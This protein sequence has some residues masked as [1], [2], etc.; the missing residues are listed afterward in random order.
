ML[1]KTI[2]I[3]RIPAR[4][5]PLGRLYPVFEGVYLPPTRE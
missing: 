5:R 1:V 2:F 4:S 3:F